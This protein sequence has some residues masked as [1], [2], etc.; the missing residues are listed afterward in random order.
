M[1]MRPYVV[2]PGDYVTKLASQ[3][4]FEPEETWNHD[5]NASL[6]E[7][8]ESRDL[9]APGD[10]LY[11]PDTPPEPLTLTAQSS[12][13]FQATL[14][15]VKTTVTLVKNGEALANEPYVI[16]GAGPEAKKGQSDGDG[17]IEIEASVRH[18]RVHV[19]LPERGH[20]FE[21]M[22][23]HLDPPTVPS[24]WRQRLRSLGHYGWHSGMLSD[25]EVE[26]EGAIDRMAIEAFQ[27]ANEVT[28]TGEMDEATIA[29]LKAVFGC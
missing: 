19:V 10:V 1:G 4:G 9:L 14:P 8:R 15:R 24:G 22:I 17:K 23:G 16:T 27:A 11:V 20:S 12:N 29:K 18:D 13:R 26:D 21:V 28:V 6:R 2:K 5:K 7:K 25:G 3:L